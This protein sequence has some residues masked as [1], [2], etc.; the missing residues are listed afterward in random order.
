[1]MN[2]SKTL[3]KALS[4]AVPARGHQLPFTDTHCCVCVSGQPPTP[5]SLKGI[6]NQVGLDSSLLSIEF[7]RPAPGQRGIV[8]TLPHGDSEP[9]KL[10]I[11]EAG[12]GWPHSFTV[13][14][15]YTH[16][17]PAGRGALPR[18]ALEEADHWAQGGLLPPLPSWLGRERARRV[19]VAV[20]PD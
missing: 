9:W 2:N 7:F 5:A 12:A 6:C 4:P 15:M 19:K 10:L 1:M 18:R 16:T 8:E 14:H 20:Q 11:L 3:G 17:Q 13:L